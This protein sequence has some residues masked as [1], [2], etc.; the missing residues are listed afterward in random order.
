M[1]EV[2]RS[3]LWLRRALL[4][5][6]TVIL[7]TLVAGCVSRPDLDSVQ[8]RTR[9]RTYAVKPPYGKISL[10]IPKGR[11]S[12][13]P[14]GQE[15]ETY[16][17]NYFYFADEAINLVVSGTFR[18]A[19]VFPGIKTLWECQVQEWVSRDQPIPQ[20]PLFEDVGDWHTVIYDLTAPDGHSSHIWTHWTNEGIWI[21]LHLSITS[22]QEV[23]GAKSRLLG[24]LRRIRVEIPEP[25]ARGG[26][27]FHGHRPKK[28]G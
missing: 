14:L 9:S 24:L 6:S 19:K 23:M 8:I 1:C 22:D 25:P 4:L 5:D 18:P 17:P 11:L 7:L 26:H 15:G 2:D 20:D 12:K 27:G 13:K 16:N 21:D 10:H 3:G 28:R